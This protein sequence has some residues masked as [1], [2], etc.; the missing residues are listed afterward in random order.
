MLILGSLLF[1][2]YLTMSESEIMEQNL[3][4]IISQHSSMPDLCEG[5][6]VNP[7]Q[8]HLFG[9]K[10]KKSKVRPDPSE[11]QYYENEPLPLF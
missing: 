8:K 5:E 3:A 7:F 2:S 11:P 1:I 6:P 4:R 9:K 10:M